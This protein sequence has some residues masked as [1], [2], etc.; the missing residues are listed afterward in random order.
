MRDNP[1]DMKLRL[2]PSMRQSIEDAAKHNKRTM[3]GEIIARLEWSFEEEKRRSSESPLFATL[4][5]IS[6]NSIEERLVDYG[7]RIEALEA[8]VRDLEKKP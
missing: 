2:S 1:P 5:K 4:K 3:T 7:Q 8:K 6:K